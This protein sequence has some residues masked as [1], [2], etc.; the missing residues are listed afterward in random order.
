MGVAFREHHA[1]LLTRLAQ[2]FGD[3]AR[4][5]AGDTRIKHQ[6]VRRKTLIPNNA[7]SVSL[8]YMGFGRS[9]QKF[10]RNLGVLSSADA[11]S[12]MTWYSNL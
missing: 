12:Q 4:P 11:L 10:S 7:S 8:S 9:L 2:A 5:D 6:A 3:P 1:I